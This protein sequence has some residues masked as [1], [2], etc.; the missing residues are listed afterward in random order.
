M[1]LVDRHGTIRGPESENQLPSRSRFRVLNGDGSLRDGPPLSGYYTTYPALDAAGN[2]VFWRDGKLVT[3]DGNLQ[4][5]ELFADQDD[6][7]VMSRVLL[8]DHGQVFLAL[9]DELLIFHNTGLTALDTGPWPCADGNLCSDDRWS[10]RGGGRMSTEGGVSG[11]DDCGSGKVRGGDEY[12]EAPVS[13]RHPVLTCVPVD[14]R[15]NRV[16]GRY[17]GQSDETISYADA[18]VEVEIFVQTASSRHAEGTR[19]SGG[20][21]GGS[22]Q[23]RKHR[24]SRMK[25]A[26]AT[27]GRQDSGPLRALPPVRAIRK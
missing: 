16:Y 26:P 14:R 5:R 17:T 23:R 1:L 12:G 6:R 11:N 18:V 13:D 21:I 3:V 24:V 15:R 2:T 22:G 19:C 9:H 7:A 25:G 8:L 20:G 27:F 4:A 10:V